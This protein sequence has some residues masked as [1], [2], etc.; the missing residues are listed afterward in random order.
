[1]MSKQVYD[2]F[3]VDAVKLAAPMKEFN[4][5]A[6]SHLEKLVALNLESAKAYADLGISQL[7]AVGEVQDFDGLQGLMSKQ[8]EVVKQVGE[9]LAAD[10]RAVVELSK[11]F[12]TDAQ[13]LAKESLSAVNLKAA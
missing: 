5:L 2:V 4:R 11:A 12:N 9:K 7:K 3:G 13:K 6:V 10:A 1:M 8:N